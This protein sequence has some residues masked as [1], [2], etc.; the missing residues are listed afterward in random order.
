[1]YSTVMDNRAIENI[2]DLELHFCANKPS[3]TVE[4]HGDWVIAWRITFKVTHFVFPHHEAELE[5]YN[6]YITSYFVSVHPGSLL[7]YFAPCN[8]TPAIPFPAIL[9]IQVSMPFTTN[10]QNPP[11]ILNPLDV[12]WG[13]RKNDH[14]HTQVLATSP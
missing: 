14:N 10:S 9:G 1:M 7:S 11:P 4:T 2:G 3:K 12:H 8:V 13:Q 5:E 6:D